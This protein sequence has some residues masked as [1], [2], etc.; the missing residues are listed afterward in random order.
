MV[1]IAMFGLAKGYLIQNN[2][3]CN[4]FPQSLKHF[5]NQVYEHDDIWSFLKKKIFGHISGSNWH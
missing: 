4:F 5:D 1:N 2:L 3:S